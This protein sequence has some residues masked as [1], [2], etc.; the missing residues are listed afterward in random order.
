MKG[1][2]VEVDVAA[3]RRLLGEAE[4]DA[5]LLSE[6]FTHQSYAHG[7]NG[8]RDNQRLEFL[9]D[10]VLGLLSADVLFSEDPDADEGALTARRSALVSGETL[11]EIAGTLELAR[12]MRFAPGVHDA[13]ERS[14]RRTSAAL[15]EA[16][17][18]AVWLWGG[19]DAARRLFLR[20]FAGRLEG[21]RAG[22]VPDDPRGRLQ[23]ISRER[24]G[25]GPAYSI[26]GVEGNGRD[27]VFTARVEAIGQ[28]A[29]AEGS[30][31]RRAFAAAAEKLLK[32]IEDS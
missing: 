2:P 3:I 16:V 23:A 7:R 20:L 9:G 25:E 17:F 21:L 32:A 18:G 10:A 8:V 12:F 30:S 11:A 19:I 6:A 29:V 31:K 15:V 4:C 14:G 22:P 1:T 24:A 28:E 26:L 5:G 13:T 27:F